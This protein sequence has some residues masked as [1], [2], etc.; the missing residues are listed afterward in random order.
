MGIEVGT[1]K[2]KF[3]R[4]SPRKAMLVAKLV[5]G[6]KLDD[7]LN[8]LRFNKR[9]VSKDFLKL[10]QSALANAEQLKAV[11][12]DKI[13]VSTLTVDQGA[14]YKRWR[15]RARGSA[16]KILKRTSHLTVVLSEK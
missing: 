8:I 13:Y 10:L 7:A 2:V 6:K 5:R 14:T 9:Y 1:A 15:P 11:D 4:V 3:L 12:V 16:S